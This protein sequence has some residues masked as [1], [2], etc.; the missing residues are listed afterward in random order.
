[1]RLFN[2]LQE[3]RGVVDLNGDSADDVGALIRLCSLP[4]GRVTL[5]S[6]LLENMFL[7]VQGEPHH[8]GSAVPSHEATPF[9]VVVARIPPAEAAKQAAVI[10]AAMGGVMPITAMRGGGEGG[11]DACVCVRACAC[12]CA[13]TCV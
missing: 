5:S 12:V 7:G 6:A 13:R 8:V 9:H 4:D 2:P 11:R 10:R 1:L 3:R